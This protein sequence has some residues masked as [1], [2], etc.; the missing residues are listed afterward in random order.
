MT[1]VI[2]LIP[3]NAMFPFLSAETSDNYFPK[4]LLS[5]YEESITSS[6]GLIPTPYEQALNGQEGVT[7]ETLGGI[8]DA[9]PESQG[10]YDPGVRS[11]YTAWHKKYP[12][13]VGNE[14][15]QEPYIEEQGPVQSWCTAIRLFATAATNAG[16]HL[17]RRTFVQAMS[18]IKNFPGGISPVWTFGSNK[19][20]GPTEYQV[21]EIHNNV[22]PSSLC[23]L[24]VSGKP[25]G[26]CWVT[27]P[28]LPSV[29]HAGR[30]G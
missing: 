25:Q 15:P 16:S 4:L 21:V 3:F 29:A 10:G 17:D 14:K 11:C 19:F 7:T 13:P 23:K 9:V 8:D 27:D 5:D 12:Q 18:R 6:L 24:T 26:T 28:A 20:Y 22:P 30:L 2:P 1:S